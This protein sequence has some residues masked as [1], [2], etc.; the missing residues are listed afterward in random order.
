[1][2]D[3]NYESETAF[4]E[5]EKVINYFNSLGVDGFRLD[6]IS[7][8][9]K[10]LTFVDA[11]DESKTF[12]KFSNLE[13]NHKYLKRF[14]KSFRYNKM[15]TMGEL[16]GEPTEDDLIRYTAEKEIDMIFSFEQMDVFSAENKISREGLMKVLKYKESLSSYKGWS[17]LFWL[18]HDYPRLISKIRGEKDPKSAQICLATLMYF[19]KGTPI[20]YNGEEIGMEN[21]P[22][23]KPKEFCDINSIMLLKNCGNKENTFAYLQE[24]SRDHA[25]TVMQ[26]TSEKNAGFST[27]KPW[28]HVNKNY[29]QINVQ[30][31]LEEDDSILNN[32]KKVL[33]ARKTVGDILATAKYEFF[34]DGSLLGF[35][36]K[37]KKMRVFVV[38]NFS[39]ESKE[40]DFSGAEVLFSN[41]AVGTVMLPYQV[42]VYKK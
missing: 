6:A 42:A 2:P 3:V 26:W 32:Y 24:S 17:V 14:N 5:M 21:Y 19:L 27:V 41:F 39:G 18:N 34:D 36:A 15:V 38:C 9:G 16:G 23:T 10:D 7:H 25:R 22:F 8:L 30:A 35:I 13:N 40:F 12:K 1:M 4:R 29:K 31:E 28:F 33:S 37:R 20:I 11:D